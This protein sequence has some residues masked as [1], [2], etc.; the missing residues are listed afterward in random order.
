MHTDFDI[1][2]KEN[3]EK[4]SRVYLTRR[5]PVIVRVDGKAFHTFCKRFDKPYDK[6][7]NA[8][9]NTVMLELCKKIQGAQFAQR[10]SDEISILLTDY[11]ALQT[12]AYFD[13]QVQKICSVVASMAS[14]LF[15]KELIFREDSFTEGGRFSIRDEYPVFDAR[16]FNIPKEEVGNYFWWRMLDAKRGSINMYGQA[17]F[18]HKELQGLSCDQIQEKLWQ[19]RDLNWDSLSQGVKV[20]FICR[21]EMVDKPIPAGPRVGE[22]VKRNVWIVEG[23]P[24]LRSELEDLIVPVV[25]K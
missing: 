1:R 21:K 7:L 2:M 18:S 8:S 19:E 11:D 16:C 12:D 6:C 3:Y 24:K 4:R 14:T 9:L 10:H 23:A 15:V 20:G 25:F 22:M 13:Y 17:H 5:T